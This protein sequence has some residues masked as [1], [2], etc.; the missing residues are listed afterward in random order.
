VH[1]LAWLGLHP[2]SLRE[3]VLT[4]SPVEVIMPVLQNLADDG[5]ILYLDVKRTRGHTDIVL[6]SRPYKL[7]E[8]HVD[9]SDPPTLFASGR[10]D[11]RCY[12]GRRGQGLRKLLVLSDLTTIKAPGFNIRVLPDE[13]EVVRTKHTTGVS[14][15]A[16]IPGWGISDCE[17]IVDWASTLL[18]PVQVNGGMVRMPFPDVDLEVRLPSVSCHEAKDLQV[19]CVGKASLYPVIKGTSWQ[20]PS[21]LYECGFPIETF[22]MTH[23]VDVSQRIPLDVKG[24]PPVWWV[25]NL[26]RLVLHHQ[27]LQ[28]QNSGLL[29]A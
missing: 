25:R 20:G 22:Q 16:R 21:W 28:M 1:E 24:K 4:L 26:Q 17:T 27:M 19:P 11:D 5:S 8:G 15:H 29:G 13:V 12:S 18:R 23:H 14:I 10:G 9:P 2:Q 7:P 3:E 6:E